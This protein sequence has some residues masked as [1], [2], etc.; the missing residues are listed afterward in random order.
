[1][2]KDQKAVTGSCAQQESDD[3]DPQPA[4]ARSV[5]PAAYRDSAEI[6]KGLR[7]VVIKHNDAEY[8][9]RITS[10]GKLILTK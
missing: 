1:M 2:S 9:L 8:R 5:N 7:E 4:V 6:F 10:S 3:A